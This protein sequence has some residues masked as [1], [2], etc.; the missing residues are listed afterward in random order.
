MPRGR[1]PQNEQIELDAEQ[2]QD[3]FRERVVGLHLKNRFYE[4]ATKA[5]ELFNC[6]ICLSDI[7]QTEAF[8]LLVCGHHTCMSCW[9]YTPEPKKCSICRN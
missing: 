8:C 6:P 4:Y 3:M 2:L 1:R 7:K 5:E 9:H